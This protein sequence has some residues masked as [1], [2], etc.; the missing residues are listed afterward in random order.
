[1]VALCI[2][3][4]VAEFKDFGGDNTKLYVAFYSI[5]IALNL[6][7]TSLIAGRLIHARRHISKLLGA[8][9]SSLSQMH[10][11][12]TGAS[13]ILIESA[14]PLA[15]LGLGS[16]IMKGVSS[17]LQDR[18]EASG[19]AMIADYVFGTLYPA[20]VVRATVLFVHSSVCYL[21]Y[22]LTWLSDQVLSPQMIIFRVT[23]GRSWIAGVHK[24]F[25]TEGDDMRGTVIGGFGGTK[26]L[27]FAQ[28]DTTKTLDFD[29]PSMATHSKNV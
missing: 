2:L 9:T 15:I 29:S 1:M 16:A 27:V 8:S 10:R 26:G 28:A 25:L 11:D 18:P 23:T 13:A 5:S 21:A 24:T 7:V 22:L 4:V 19:R 14:V 12:I 20:F 3:L 6:M 17:A